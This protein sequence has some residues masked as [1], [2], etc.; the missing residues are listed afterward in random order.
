MEHTSEQILAVLEDT[1]LLLRKA[2]INLKKC[3]KQRLTKGY[4]ETRLKSIEQ[5]WETFKNTHNEL[6]RC[7]PKE[8]RIDMPY[9]TNED[10]F[11][12]EDLYLCIQADLLDLLSTLSG[13]RSMEIGNSSTSSTGVNNDSSPVKLPQIHLPKFTGI[14]EEW[15]TFQD[16]FVSLVHNNNSLSKVQKLHY[17]KSSTGAEAEVLLKHIQVTEANYEQAWEVLKT[18]YGNKRMIVNS[19]LKKMFSQRRLFSQTANQL[20]C[21]LDTTN[22]CLNDLKNQ[23]ISTDS[24]DPII[25]FLITQKLDPESHRSW[26]EHAYKDNSQELPTWND[27]ANFLQSKFRTLELITPP[28]QSREKILKPKEYTVHL[29]TEAANKNR[30][31]LLCNDTH[32][33][34]H[35][36]GF[37]KMEPTERS[38][39]VRDKKLCYNCL[40]PRHSAKKCRLQMLCRVCHKRHHTLLHQSG[41]LTSDTSK[42]VDVEA[43]HIQIE[44]DCKN[45]ASSNVVYASHHVTSTST[46]LLA[47]ALVPIKGETGCTTMLRALVDNGSQATLIT[48]RA[49]QILNL[50]KIHVEGKITGVGSTTTAIKYATEIKI[51]SRYDETINMK[52]KAYIMPTRLTSQ[53]PSMTISTSNW[54]HLKNLDLADPSFNQPGR[55]DMLLGVDVC[56]QIMKGEYIK[57]PPGTPS[58]QNTSLGWILYGLV[59]DQRKRDEI[60]I[61]HQEVDL[62]NMLK[63]MWELQTNEKQALT[64]EERRCEEIYKNTYVR[65]EEGRYVVKL[66]TKTEKLLSIEGQTR[67]IALRRLKYIERSFEKNHKLKAEYTSVMEEYLEMNHMEEVAENEMN[68][69]AVYLP[70]HAV[71]KEEKETT[72]VRIVFDAS[73]KGKN[74][75]SLNDELMV[76]PQLQEDMRN[77]VMRWRMKKICFV[78]DVQ[79]MYRNIL[80]AKEDTNY[81]RILWRKEANQ[82]IKDYRLLR[83]TFGTACAPYLAVKTL[84]QIAEDEGEDKPNAVRTIKEDFY[85]DDLMSGSDTLQEAIHTAKD[86][87]CI[88]RKGGFNLQKWCSNDVEFLRQFDPSNRSSRV[89]LDIKID[90]TIQTLGLSWN[91]GRDTLQYKF[92]LPD[93]DS[94]TYKVTKRSILAEMQRLFDPLGWLAPALV[95]AKMLLQKL[96]LQRLTWDEEVDTDTKDEWMVLRHSFYHVKE[97]ELQRWLQSTEKEIDKV[98]IHGFCDAS[99]KAYAAVAYMRVVNQNGE[100]KVGILA[101]K[102]R[103]APVKP[104]SLPRLELCGALLLAKLLKQIKDATRVPQ[105]Q[106]YACTDSTIVL[107]WLCGDP[108]RWQTFVRNRV[109][110]ILDAMGNTNWYH[111]PTNENPADVASRGM[112]LPE[113]KNYKMW[114]EGPDFL[115][116]PINY[117]RMKNITTKLEKRATIQTNLKIEMKDME[118]SIITQLENFE[119][120]SE[121]LNTLVYCKRFLNYKKHSDKPTAITTNELDE[122]LNICIRLTQKE[123]FEEEIIRLKENKPVRKDS[124]LKSLEPYLDRDNILRVGGRLRHANLK[125]NMKHPIILDSKNYLAKLVVAD[126]HLKTLHGGVQLMIGYLRSKYWILKAKN[127]VKKT[128]H[129]CLI[130]AKQSASARTQLMGDL[131]EVRV[132]PARPFLHSGVDFAGPYQVLMSRSR[133]AKCSK[134]YIAIFVCMSTKA[135]HLELVGDLTAESFIGAFRRFVARRGRCT[136]MWS[137]QGRNFVGANKELAAAW[138]EAGLGFEEDV[139]QTLALDGTQWHFIPAYSP[140]VGGLWEAGVKS[141]KHHMKRILTNNVTYEELSTLTCQIE[142]CLNSR[143]LR[144]IDDSDIEDINPLTPG[145]FLI[146][147]APVT[148]PNPNL[149]NVKVSHLSRWQYLQKL[150]SDLWHRWQNEYICTLQQRQKWQNK[151]KEF[152]I[153]DIVLIKSENLPPGKWA[154]GRIVD[155]HP[156]TDGVTRVYSVKSKDSIVRRIVN[157]LCPLPIDTEN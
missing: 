84:L 99:T 68:L 113:L 30:S 104:V 130:C 42:Q 58:A 2:Q 97:I 132:T 87:E 45:V 89:R 78:A 121:L 26:E 77:I 135:T 110:E 120:L 71:I 80:V 10:Y 7:T 75:V 3:P 131:P 35:C 109:V 8:R 146:G 91:I 150:L 101:A 82:P 33:L 81:Q 124:K 145:H 31:C 141:M 49:A 96:W 22:Q 116:K 155:K 34:S 36:K 59:Q 9:F 122:S 118:R 144:P 56:A 12:Y 76:G 98:T 32:T 86:V 66:P 100:V 94:L 50:K 108:N 70:H 137:D 149:Q 85:M 19:L 129:L 140:H 65:N 44:G 72:K 136:H 106:I 60:T 92:N 40:A 21:L 5:Y 128:I 93:I 11:I 151:N 105:N 20:K 41:N 62:D 90:G 127:L 74:K 112:L 142:A 157:K 63:L 64:E 54:S 114:W 69:P 48:E 73:A 53:L 16:L 39:F 139:A 46:A 61:M 13:S 153:G 1:A 28:V 115:L 125:E 15:T 102:T 52:I 29:T 119:T 117:V 25:I 103:V 24:W 4:V 126:S 17:L 37:T 111:V 47:T 55:I 143:P 57:G 147:E 95:P 156:G 154:L 38:Q 51:L 6:I 83:V 43:H 79:K 67:D 133:G 152:A 107:S 27:L 148:V 18:R 134:A 123:T 23:N 138:A 88:L 14:Y